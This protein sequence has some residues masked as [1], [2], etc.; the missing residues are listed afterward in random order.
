MAEVLDF[1]I[2]LVSD[3][4]SVRIDIEPPLPEEEKELIRD[5]PAM[6]ELPED[7]L[8]FNDRAPDSG[9][10]FTEINCAQVRTGAEYRGLSL[11][12]SNFAREIAEVLEAHGRAVKL[13]PV[14]KPIEQSGYLFLS[15][16]TERPLV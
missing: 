2:Q 10:H 1:T 15:L 4:Q 14:I 11:D 16:S 8:V 6:R 13:D 3:G 7:S 9:H 12:E 5:T